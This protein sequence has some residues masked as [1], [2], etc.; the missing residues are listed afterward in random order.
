M[1][2]E[3]GWEAMAGYSSLGGL[4]KK[5]DKSGSFVVETCRLDEVVNERIRFLKIDTQGGELGVLRGCSRLFEKDFIDIMMIE[6]DGNE[7]VLIEILDRGFTIIDNECTIAP[8]GVEDLNA[9][10]VVR[11]GNLSTGK[12]AVTA[13]PKVHIEN[14]YE[15][16]DFL[17]NQR[18]VGI[19]WTDLIC[20]SQS[21]KA[22]FMASIQKSAS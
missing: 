5:W 15:Y 20:V 18:R 17:K 21:A 14:P 10:N 1:G 3:K 8:E 16:C 12:P 6:F 19:V 13:W 7:R 11:R 4:S 2:I 9:W 22:A